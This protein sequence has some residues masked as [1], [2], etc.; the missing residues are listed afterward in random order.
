MFIL[1]IHKRLISFVYLTDR[2]QWQY[3]WYFILKRWILSRPCIKFQNDNSRHCALNSKSKKKLANVVGYPF[4]CLLSLG[5]TDTKSSLVL[6][7][8]FFLHIF[9]VYTKSVH[10]RLVSFVK[11]RKEAK[12]NLSIKPAVKNC[13]CMYARTNVAAIIKKKKEGEQNRIDEREK[14]IRRN[15]ITLFLVSYIPLFI[16]TSNYLLLVSFIHSFSLFFSS[17]T[18]LQYDYEY[19]RIKESKSS[20]FIF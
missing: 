19:K 12:A 20:Y 9:Y 10:V 3:N 8:F 14:K 15:E 11:E 17:F 6:R 13:L 4:F 16:I 7:S 5:N 18:H 2:H 1:T